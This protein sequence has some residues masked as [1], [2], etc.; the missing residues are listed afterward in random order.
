M[1]PAGRAAAAARVRPAAQHLDVPPLPPRAA[2]AGS[3][4]AGS[5]A[6]S[7]G[8][9]T[10]LR[11]RQGAQLAQLLG[12]ELGLGGAASADHVDVLDAAVRERAERPLR[13]I[14]GGE[15]V[16]ATGQHPRHVHRHV[17]HADHHGGP[18]RRGRNGPRP[19]P[20]ARCTRTTNSVAGW[21]PGSSSPGMPRCR[22]VAAP[23]QY[24]TAW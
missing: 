4:Y 1:D 10:H 14:G 5:S 15:L 12:G 3:R 2:R 7:P 19:H 9:T 22:S 6:S 8:R 24:T 11:V 16:G 23:T 13:H 20:D 18:G 21:L 17:P